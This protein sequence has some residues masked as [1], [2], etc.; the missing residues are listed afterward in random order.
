MDRFAI[1][2]IFFA[3]SAFVFAQN[4]SSE[5]ATAAGIKITPTDLS[6]NA[7]SLYEKQKEVAASNRKRILEK[8]IAEMLLNAEGRSRGTTGEQVLADEFKRLKQPTDV[9]IKTIYD[10]NRGAIGNRSLEEVRPQIVRFLMQEPEEKAENELLTRLKTKYRFSLGTDVN[11]APRKP[12]DVLFILDGKHYTVGE[13]ENEERIALNDVEVHIY[14]ELYAAT[15]DALLMKLIDKEAVEKGTD[16]GAVIAAE[17][18]D[19]MRE[20]SDAERTNLWYDLQR[21]LFAKYGAKILLPEPMPLVLEVSADDDPFLGPATAPVTV[22]M[23][24]DFQCGACAAFGPVARK[25]AVEFG[26]KVRLVIRDFPLESIHENAFRAALAANAAARQ[27][28][29]FEYGAILYGNQRSLDD[30]SLLRYA[31][32]LKLDLE[33]FKADIADPKNAEEIRKDI[34]DGNKYGVSGTPTVYINGI[35]HHGLS[36]PKFRVAIER[37][38]N[39]VK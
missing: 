29:Y 13:F 30:A 38:L 23:F 39:R 11:A 18:T 37:T 21:R 24:N 7:R 12:A 4:P 33:R 26:S 36:E 14:E 17:I 25:V 31:G 20:F 34:A 1:V 32:E 16:P 35:K 8:K 5:L 3:F 10:A 28:K 22:V 27:G 9:E 2:V 19:K 6:E 15:E